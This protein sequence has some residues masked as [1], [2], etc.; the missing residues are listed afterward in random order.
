MIYVFA[1]LAAFLT[2]VAVLHFRDRKG[3]MGLWFLLC[4]AINA[5]CAISMYVKQDPHAFRLHDRSE[6]PNEPDPGMPD[7]R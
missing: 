2:I 5:G 3:A 7:R 1:A 6:Y 4:A